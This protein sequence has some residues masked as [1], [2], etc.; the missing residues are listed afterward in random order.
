MYSSGYKNNKSTWGKSRTS[1]NCFIT[2]IAT[3]KDVS[4]YLSNWNIDKGGW[5]YIYKVL[6]FKGLY[7]C[8]GWKKKESSF[9][10]DDIERE[11]DNLIK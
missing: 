8:I 2:T 9:I 4:F 1:I 10:G 5:A 11:R 6:D 7:I 3:R